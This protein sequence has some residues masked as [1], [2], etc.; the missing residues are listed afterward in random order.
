MPEINFTFGVL[1][2]K[3][4]KCIQ[5]LNPFDLLQAHS[6]LLQLFYP[7]LC[8]PLSPQTSVTVDAY[9]DRC[10]GDSLALRSDA[11]LCILPAVFKTTSKLGLAL[12]TEFCPFREKT[13]FEFYLLRSFLLGYNW[14]FRVK[15]AIITREDLKC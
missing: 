14:R 2:T 4:Y 6:C 15:W 12:T 7:M 1:Q 8:S 3:M 11:E 5:S 10:G 13:L 9:R